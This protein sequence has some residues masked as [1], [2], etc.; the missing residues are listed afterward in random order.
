MLALKSAFNQK[1]QTGYELD[2]LIQ[3]EPINTVK[4][5]KHE[6]NILSGFSKNNG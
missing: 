1:H 4:H 5:S 3:E 6:I 2:Q